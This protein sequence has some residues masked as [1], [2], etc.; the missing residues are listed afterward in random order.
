[1]LDSDPLALAGT[2]HRLHRS[3]RRCTFSQKSGLFPNTQEGERRG[4]GH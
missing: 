3:L 2:V 4:C 1:M